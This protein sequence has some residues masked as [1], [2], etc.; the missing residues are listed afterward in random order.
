M[1]YLKQYIRTHNK[2]RVAGRSCSAICPPPPTAYSHQSSHLVPSGNRYCIHLFFLFYQ[3]RSAE[4]SYYLHSL[5]QV[6]SGVPL[7]RATV[8]WRTDT[9]RLLL[10]YQINNASKLFQYD[11]FVVL[12]KLFFLQ[13]VPNLVQLRRVSLRICF[14]NSASCSFFVKSYS[15]VISHSFL[16]SYHCVTWYY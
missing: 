3:A 5:F 7:F 15:N 6:P 2:R 16:H 4:V 12:R 1:V 14:V 10:G 9:R 11:H 13:L 8:F